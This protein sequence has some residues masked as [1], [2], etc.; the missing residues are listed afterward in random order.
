MIERHLIRRLARK[1]AVSEGLAADSLDQLVHDIVRRLRRKESAE[2]PGVAKLVP[3]A[4]G[5]V[6]ALPLKGR[7]GKRNEGS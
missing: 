4:D 3:Q 1:A 5:R 7:Q 6:E 2:V